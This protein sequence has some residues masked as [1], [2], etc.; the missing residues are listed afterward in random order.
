VIHYNQSECVHVCMS[1]YIST[2]IPVK[3]VILDLW[4]WRAMWL[5]A[6]CARLYV[7]Y[8]RPSGEAVV[9]PGQYC[10]VSSNSILGTL[11]NSPT[12]TFHIEVVEGPPSVAWL[13]GYHQRR[14]LF[15]FWRRKSSRSCG[16]V[17]VERG[18][19]STAVPGAWKL[20]TVPMNFFG[21]SGWCH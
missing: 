7:Q 17:A 12:R 1:Y 19:P 14:W 2:S 21:T 11:L 18:Q 4:Q 9:T 13:R 10:S 3:W 15:E 8:H 5:P 20:G 6:P 16:N